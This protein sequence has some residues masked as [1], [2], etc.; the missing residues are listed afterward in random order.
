MRLKELKGRFERS[1]M[2]DINFFVINSTP[3]TIVE[4]GEIEIEEDTWKAISP[5]E[6]EGFPLVETSLES[7][8]K[9]LG[10]EFYLIEDNSQLQIWKKL[11]VS[12][13]QILVVD[14]S[15]FKLLFTLD[16]FFIDIV[17]LFYLHF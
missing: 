14:G 6:A 15:V 12:R 4:Q 11:H 7:L 10:P 2:V 13:D 17:F 16:L 3:T 1:G 8:N 5:I 9:T